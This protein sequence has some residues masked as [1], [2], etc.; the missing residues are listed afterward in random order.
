MSSRTEV[1]FKPVGKYCITVACNT[2]LSGKLDGT[3]SW[4]V[5]LSAVDC[6]EADHEQLSKLLNKQTKLFASADGDL[7]YTGCVKHHIQ[8]KLGSLD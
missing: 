4:V 8:L 1:E 5:E 7:G 2:A 3:E 6:T